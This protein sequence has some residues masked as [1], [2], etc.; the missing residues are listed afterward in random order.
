MPSLR[1]SKSN[2]RPTP[3]HSDNPEIFVE[4]G[5]MNAH[6]H[7]LEVPARRGTGVLQPWIPVERGGD[8][9]AIHQRHHQLIGSEGNRDRPDIADINFQSAYPSA[10]SSLR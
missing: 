2:A 5:P 10:N 1:F 9:A 8:P 4:L 3:Q 6:R 7:Q